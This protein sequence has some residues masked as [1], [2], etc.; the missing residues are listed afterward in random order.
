MKMARK[1]LFALPLAMLFMS[2]II[3]DDYKIIDFKLHGTWTS[4]D[5]KNGYSGTLVI[6]IDTI[7]ITGYDKSQTLWY[8]NDAKRP[9]REFARNVPL[10]CYS[11]DGK[12]FITT[13]EDGEESIPYSYSTKGQDKFLRFSFGGREE[14]LKRTGN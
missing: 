9:F 7:T 4:T 13:V 11:D 12:L 10:P 14:G 2:C 3:N 1:W 8:E 5:T 6:D